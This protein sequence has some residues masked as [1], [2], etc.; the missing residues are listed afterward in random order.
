MT[1]RTRNVEV[2]L[3]N[4]SMEEYRRFPVEKDH[5]HSMSVVS[6]GDG[7]SRETN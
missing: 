3:Y 6:S 2:P 5:I 7:L 4:T 1:P